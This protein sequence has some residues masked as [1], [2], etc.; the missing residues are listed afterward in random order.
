ME[1]EPETLDD[2]GHSEQG[3]T[4]GEV[5]GEIQ[6]EDDIH[7]GVEVEETLRASPVADKMPTE[8]HRT[9]EACEV[10]ADNSQSKTEAV[11]S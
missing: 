2:A 5:S 4:S 9:V 11:C 7:G 6:G 8:P 3:K 1:N 10:H